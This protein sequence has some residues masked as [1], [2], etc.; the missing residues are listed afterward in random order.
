MTSP[1]CKILSLNVRGLKNR[2]KRRSVFK[3]LKDQN[4]LFYCL[5]ET[6]SEPKDELIW[7]NEWGGG[8]FFS[9]GSNHQ[10]GV[11]ILLNPASKLAIEECHMDN[12]GRIV[13][14]NVV[15]NNLRFSIC[16]IYAP[17]C[18]AEQ[19]KFAQT[20]NAF[21]LRYLSVDKLI[22]GGDW[23]CDSGVHR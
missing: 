12:E 4:C 6:Y 16:N 21:L 14:V 15:L 17:N 20:L 18:L 11:C 1:R 7:R 22:I 23:K 13:A 9:H 5:Q 19:T 3:Y 2:L 8:I 10:K